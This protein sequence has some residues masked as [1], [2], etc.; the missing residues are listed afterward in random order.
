MTT[1]FLHDPHLGHSRDLGWLEFFDVQPG[2][3]RAAEKSC[4]RQWLLS[5]AGLQEGQMRH[6][7]VADEPAAIAGAAGG[8]AL[9]YACCPTRGSATGSAAA[10]IELVPTVRDHHAQTRHGGG[11]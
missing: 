5:L 4:V 11:L 10:R 1:G 9:A 8:S 6:Q 3:F 7:G 2:A